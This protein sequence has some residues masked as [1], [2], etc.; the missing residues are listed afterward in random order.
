MAS[1]K[2]AM[3][4]LRIGLASIVVLSTACG[5]NSSSDSQSFVSAYCTEIAKCCGQIGL[6]SDGKMCRQLMALGTA[7]GSYS[8]SAGDACLAETGASALARCI[9]L[10]LDCA[11]AC[12]ATGS[13]LIRRT[14][15]TSALMVQML[16]TCAD[17]CRLCADECDRHAGHHCR[18]CAEAC[19][20]C[21]RACLHAAMA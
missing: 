16:E 19:R 12:A 5:R 9:R 1:A 10:D 6:P 3:K 14:A 4:I 13:V 18:I 20:Q 21:E 8:A 15:A 7:G 11:D 2:V 17:F